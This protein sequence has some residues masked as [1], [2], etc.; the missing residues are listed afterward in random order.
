MI[1]FDDSETEVTAF[2]DYPGSAL[3]DQYHQSSGSSSLSSKSKTSRAKKRA[4]NRKKN[5]KN[6]KKKPASRAASNEVRL[7]KPPLTRLPLT[8]SSIE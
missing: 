5:K 2:A 6:K 1:D 8:I 4:S 7:V 3:S